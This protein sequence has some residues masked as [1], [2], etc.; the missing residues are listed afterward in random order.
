MIKNVVIV[1]S[2]YVG[3][4]AAAGF[5]EAGHR[6][7]GVDVNVDK[8][9]KIKAGISPIYEPGLDEM[10]AKHQASGL[11]KFTTD[12]QGGIAEADAVFICVGTPQGEDGSADLQYVLSVA[13]EIGKAIEHRK[14]NA[15]P[16]IIVDKSTVPVGTCNR[17][18]VAVRSHT[19]R[20]FEVVSNP[21]FLREGCAIE[22][23][24]FPD[25]VV[26][27]CVTD[28]A[29][30]VMQ[31]LYQAPL[32]AAKR[33]SSEKGQFI[34]MDPASAE[35]TKYAANA[36]LALRI[37][38]MN[39]I[40]ALCEKVEANV[41]FVKVG[42]GS[43][44]RIGKYFLNPGPGFG[45]SCFPKDLQALL[46]VARENGQGLRCLEATVEVNRHQKQVLAGKIRAHFGFG[47]SKQSSLSGK[48]F[49]LWGLAFKAHT[50]DIRE[51]M[52]LELIENLT[53]QGAE[54]TV[55]DY[56][57]I[58]NVRAKIGDRV[59]YA[60]DPLSACKGADALI[61]ATEWPQYLQVDLEAVALALKTRTLF[62]GR[63]LFQP[64]AM[65]AAGW[66]YYSIGR[67]PTIA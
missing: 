40:A 17:V 42:I 24:F 64:D 13:H 12:L 34:R 43:D 6:V 31:D 4:V 45:G 22:D 28:F 23:F 66:T 58:P 53:G 48:H 60:D 2:G 41:D 37:S 16:L 15:R 5:A 14:E 55:H 56:E 47:A 61:I 65:A 46:R 52:A 35:M 27:G 21:E 63:N 19:D 36:M 30:S 29:A 33:R 3:L 18:T 51:A 38:F 10:L 50:D 32:N 67:C 62:D 49:A 44:H 59:H 26:I 8:I 20:Q 9:D 54:I 25:R 1:G 39:E 7:L 57:A 11:L